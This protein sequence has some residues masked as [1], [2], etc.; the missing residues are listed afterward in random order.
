MKRNSV[1]VTVDHEPIGEVDNDLEFNASDEAFLEVCELVNCGDDKAANDS[2]YENFEHI[3]E[4]LRKVDYET[5]GDS[6][7]E[8]LSELGELSSRLREGLV[9]GVTG[10]IGL[11]CLLLISFAALSL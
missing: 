1:K 3:C 10:F 11:T 9:R 6:L 8:D 2:F 7:D 4:L 5:T